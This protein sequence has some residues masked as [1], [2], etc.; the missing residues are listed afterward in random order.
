MQLKGLVVL[1][2]EDDPDNLEL[3]SS[4]LEGEGATVVGAGSISG[5][6]AMTSGLELSA[7]LSDL[8]LP[9]GDGCE[10]LRRLR[11][12]DGRDL[13]AI[14]LTGYSDA[15]WRSRAADCGFERYAVKPFA[16]SQVS[17]WLNE[18]TDRK[19]AVGV[20]T[21]PSVADPAVLVLRAR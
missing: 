11:E 2:V 21:C 12:R 6:I 20:A 18:L 8:E 3:L 7:L 19:S 16:L 13:P 5:A 1:V 4:Y 14:A 15:K 9:D 17:D 10:L